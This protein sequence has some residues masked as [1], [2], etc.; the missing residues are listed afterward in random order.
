M[1]ISDLKIS[2]L[3]EAELNPAEQQFVDQGA[4]EV[5]HSRNNLEIFKIMTYDA[6]RFFAKEAKWPFLKSEEQFNIISGSGPIYYIRSPNYVIATIAFYNIRQ[7][8]GIPLFELRD[9]NDKIMNL[10]DHAVI[11]DSPKSFIKTI[12]SLN[13]LY[14]RYVEEPDVDLQMTAIRQNPLAI[15]YIEYPAPLLQTIA[16]Q[17]MPLA[18]NWIRPDKTAIDPTLWEKYQDSYYATN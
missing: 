18:I 11:H 3:F 8:R 12:L 4:V 1:K 15:Q 2:K 6:A 10:F 9:L 7:S 5:I 16:L 13:G 17:K 14:L